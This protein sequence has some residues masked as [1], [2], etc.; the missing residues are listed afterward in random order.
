MKNF[1]KFE[2]AYG[3]LFDSYQAM[4]QIPWWCITEAGG[5]TFRASRANAQKGIITAMNVL[6]G[7]FKKNF[8]RTTADAYHSE[9]FSFSEFFDML[10]RYPMLAK[11]NEEALKGLLQSLKASD[12]NTAG[13]KAVPEIS[14][15]IK[16]D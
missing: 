3:A 4:N 5:D 6:K 7:W 13:L 1:K 16:N 14:E 11:E 12:L 10:R 15:F 9:Q 2:E 8:P